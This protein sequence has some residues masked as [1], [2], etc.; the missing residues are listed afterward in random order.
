METFLLNLL[1]GV[2]KI[3]FQVVWTILAIAFVIFWIIVLDW[4][5]LDAGERTSNKTARVIYLL[6]VVFFNIFGWI[7]YLILR[8]SQTIE[9]IYWADLERRYLKYETSE[10]DDCTRCGTQLYPGYTYCPTCGLEIRVKCK[11]CDV[12]IEKNSEYCPYCGVKVGKE[13]V[14]FEEEAPSREVMEQQIQA[15]KDEATKVVEA[16]QTRYSTKKRSLTVKVG[17]SIIAG[18]QALLNKAKNVAEPLKKKSEEITVKTSVKKS[19]KKKKN[20]KH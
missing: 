3:N 4:V 12:Y 9:Q 6:L 8:P 11:S 1:S 19:K 5:W 2:E 7:M 13:V 10:L 20:K 18:Y 17:S 16:E 14:T 15:S